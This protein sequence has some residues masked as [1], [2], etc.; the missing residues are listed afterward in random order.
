MKR[1]LQSGIFA[2]VV[3]LVLYVGVTAALWPEMKVPIPAAEEPG[4]VPARRPLPVVKIPSWEF[5]SPE[6]DL[7]VEELRK[8]RQALNERAQQ[9][10][11]LAARLQSERTELNVVTQAIHQMQRQLDDAVVRVSEEESAN[12]KKL[13]KV[14]AAMSSEGAAAILIRLDEVTVVKIMALM[15]ESETAP[16]LET[17]A[18][19][20]DAESKLAASISERLR[21]AVFRK[22][23]AK[24]KT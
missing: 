20:G 11:E 5:S 10:D 6:L 12:L 13:A 16:I 21:L 17:I 19:M 1:F 4:Q 14:Y 2:A 8:E 22:P 23:P 15:K 18:R 24:S 3:G 9:L 7:L